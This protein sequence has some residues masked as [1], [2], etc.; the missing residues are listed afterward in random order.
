MNKLIYL[1]GV[2]GLAALFVVF[3]HFFQ[4]YYSGLFEK[5]ENLYHNDYEYFL[6]GLPTNILYNGNFAVYI[7]FI[8]SGYVLS[9]KYF[10]TQDREVL[11]SS[12]TKRYFRLVVPILASLILG[13]ILLKLNTFTYDEVRSITKATMD[14]HFVLQHD[15]LGVIKL[16]LIDIFV[17]GEPYFNPVLWTMKYELIGS[18]LVFALLPFVVKIKKEYLIYVTYFILS[19][20][21]TVV[22]GISFSAFLLGLMLCNIERD[23]HFVREFLK[24]RYL[25]MVILLVG[26]Y[27]GS[28]PYIDTENTIYQPL[29]ILS[30]NS[31]AF[32]L[33]H[34]VGAFLIL[35]VLLNSNTMQRFF[36]KSLFDFLGKISFSIYLIHFMVITSLS[37]SI[38]MKIYGIGYSYNISFLV[39]FAISFLLMI[40]VAYLMYKYVDVLAVKLS[41]NVYKIIFKPLFTKFLKR[42]QKDDFSKE[43]VSNN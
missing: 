15:L 32:T 11:F 41:K 10:K 39:A 20:F 13:Y 25:K 5:N 9:L 43:V 16:G 18:F 40:L 12:A 22:L 2:R 29:S 30:N 3:S 4:V 28:Y 36:S 34:I 8:L 35:L 37:T 42:K 24:N 17:E 14:N 33:Y 23:G 6:S 21:V 27:L 7:F 26:I 1:E 38:F 31:L 19:I